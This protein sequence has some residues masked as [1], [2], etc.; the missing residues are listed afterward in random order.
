MLSLLDSRALPAQ[1]LD[2]SA[3]AKASEPSTLASLLKGTAGV[4]TGINREHPA[5]TR[6]LELGF[7]EG[8]R[9]ML[10][11]LAPVSRDPMVFFINGLRI[12]LRKSE[13]AAVY[14]TISDSSVE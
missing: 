8:S 1:R 12:A 3:S 13:A 5:A 4:V 11:H 14:V 10:C 6:I 2:S 9:V 7:L